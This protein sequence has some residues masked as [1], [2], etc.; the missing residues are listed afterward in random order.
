M[1]FCRQ[2][3]DDFIP[4]VQGKGGSNSLFHRKSS[5]GVRLKF[6]AFCLVTKP[7]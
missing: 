2:G 5:S 1:G 4:N 6:G 3:L 7:A